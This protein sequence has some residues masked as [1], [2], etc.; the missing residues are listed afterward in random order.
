M[1]LLL[2]VIAIVVAIVI[3]IVIVAM[4]ISLIPPYGIIIIMAA[5]LYSSMIGGLSRSN[6]YGTKCKHYQ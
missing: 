2:I 5:V 4:T 3:S 1:L 6:S